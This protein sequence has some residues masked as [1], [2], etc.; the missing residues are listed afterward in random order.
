[1][2]WGDK[3][4]NNREESD[5]AS[6]KASGQD[7]ETGSGTERDREREKRLRLLCVAC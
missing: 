4:E 5:G 1:M 6:E 7:R 3:G 2:R